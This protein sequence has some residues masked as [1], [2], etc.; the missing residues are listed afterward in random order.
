MGL[1][2]A[3]SAVWLIYFRKEFVF[4]RA[5]LLIPAGIV[6]MFALNALRISILMLI[7]D[8]GYPDI[9]IHGFHSQAGWI[10]F[11]I[12]AVALVILS[13]RLLSLPAEYSST[14]AVSNP[15]AAY[16]MPF[17][18]ILAA[19]IVSS[20]LSGRFEM[21]Y[22]VRLAAGLSLLI[23]FWPKLRS[24]NWRSS[25]LGPAAGCLVYGIW[26]LAAHYL[27]ASHDMPVQLSETSPGMREFWIVCRLMSSIA[28]VPIAE[29]L[30]YRGYLMRRI[31]SEDFESVTFRSVR[32]R[33]VILTAI[34][35]G[36]MQGVLWLPGFFAG[37]VFGLVAIARDRIGE[38]VAAHATANL[39]LAATVL[40]CHQWQ[41]W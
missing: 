30:A 38:A 41:L 21:L 36:A 27:V 19:G 35:F 23:Y 26:I 1:I 37:L 17:L 7:G 40:C 8:A 32:W 29:E 3:F 18:G 16:L 33:A 31:S 22:P 2:L 4:P 6:A 12:A 24:L 10:A 11:N 34:A 39:L 28:T 13:R 14:N 25:W 20:A 9:A 5:L 15:T